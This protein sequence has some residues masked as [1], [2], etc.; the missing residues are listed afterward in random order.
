MTAVQA[1]DFDREIQEDKEVKRKMSSI[2]EFMEDYY[3]ALRDDYDP[4]VGPE[5]G[6]LKRFCS[7]VAA[8]VVAILATKK[9]SQGSQA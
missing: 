9:H 2:P 6:R 1:V 5:P 3:Q 8:F 4:S 7:A